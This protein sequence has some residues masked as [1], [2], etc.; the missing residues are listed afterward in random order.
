L[1]CGCDDAAENDD[2]A[3]DAPGWSSRHLLPTIKALLDSLHQRLTTSAPF[4]R[5]PARIPVSTVN[6]KRL[7]KSEEA[8]G[9]KASSPK[10]SAWP[11]PRRCQPTI[12][13][14]AR[15]QSR[16]SLFYCQRRLRQRCGLRLSILKLQGIEEATHRVLQGMSPTLET[17]PHRVRHRVL[18]RFSWTI[19]PSF[20]RSRH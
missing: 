10:K 17:T 8:S 13:P 3:S 11:S 19:S 1:R 20:S 16:V 2:G 15:P 4:W 7:K 6:R 5:C 18:N 9:A 12:P 14:P